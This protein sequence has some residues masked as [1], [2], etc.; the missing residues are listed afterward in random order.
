M[1]RQT[2]HDRI[3]EAYLQMAER[4]KFRPQAPSDGMGN[5]QLSDEDLTDPKRLAKEA[6]EYADRFVKEENTQQFDIGC[7]DFTTNR[8]FVYTIEAAKA[9]CT[10]AHGIA[11]ALELLRMAVADVE[12]AAARSVG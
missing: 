7:S 1:G 12:E 11:T 4:A 8:A 9:L 10:G 2:E 3:Q 5:I 6:T